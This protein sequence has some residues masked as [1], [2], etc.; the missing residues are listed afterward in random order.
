MIG[1]KFV[2]KSSSDE[3]DFSKVEDLVIFFN[4]N[5]ANNIILQKAKILPEEFYKYIKT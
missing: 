5:K 4:N 2:T 3:T 1:L